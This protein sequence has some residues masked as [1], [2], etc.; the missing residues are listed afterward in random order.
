MEIPQVIEAIRT[1]WE[2]QFK[3][4][5]DDIKELK[6]EGKEQRSW[7]ENKLTALSCKEHGDQ[8]QGIETSI[9]KLEAEVSANRKHSEEQDRARDKK[10][11]RIWTVLGGVI[12]SVA[13][14]LIQNH[15]IK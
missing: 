4:I 5:S 15:L 11:A 9:V 3:A 8:M 12:A 14:Y 2:P 7:L 13:F 6:D 10:E 1:V